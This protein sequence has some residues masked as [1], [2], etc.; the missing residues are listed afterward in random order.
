VAEAFSAT[1]G[2]VVSVPNSAPDIGPAETTPP[3]PLSRVL[4][5][6]N[7]EQGVVSSRQ[8]TAPDIGPVQST[9][10]VVLAQQYLQFAGANADMLA[11]AGTASLAGT[12]YPLGV[13]VAITA[14]EVAT[15]DL[16][17]RPIGQWTVGT[18]YVAATASTTAPVQ[19]R[20]NILDFEVSNAT[21][22]HTVVA[23]TQNQQTPQQNVANAEAGFTSD[24]VVFTQDHTLVAVSAEAGHTVAAPGF[25]ANLVVMG[26]ESATMALLGPGFAT[27]DAVNIDQNQAQGVANAITGV[28]VAAPNLFVIPNVP[29]PA[30]RVFTPAL[31]SRTLTVGA[32]SRSFVAIAA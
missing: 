8:N 23:P 6:A 25:G 12:V 26:V 1:Q 29:T 16:D 32:E 27:S 2:F 19:L 24:P 10:P 31:E 21:Q 5:V 17:D 14:P 9:H 7:A 13:A 11:L 30:A 3:V 22:G 20:Q 18:D 15:Y 28:E 4:P